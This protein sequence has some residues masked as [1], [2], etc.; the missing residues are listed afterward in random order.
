MNGNRAKRAALRDEIL[1]KARDRVLLMGI[2]N[3]T[4]DSF[5][6]GGRF[7]DPREALRQAEVLDAEGADIIDVGGESTRPSAAQ[8]S[9]ED[10]LG[11]VLAVIPGLCASYSRIVSIDTYKASVAHAAA[12]AGAVIVN[13][14]WGMTRDTGMA[15][16]VAETASAVVVT[17]N[18]GTVQADI[19][20]A[21]DMRDFFANAFAMAAAA[22]IPREHVILDPGVG[23]GKT[24]EQ[25]FTV[26]AR[27]D[28]LMDFDV[29]VLVGVS[30]KSFIGRLLDRE[31]DDRLIGTLAAGLA[32]VQRGA[33][34]LRVH[35]VGA[36]AD[37]LKMLKAIDEAG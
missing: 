4:P 7:V 12:E 35:D 23:F 21:D 14:V 18:R 28:V 32:S 8:V 26:L 19:N 27:L 1:A 15:Q 20:I 2:L 29:P 6:D 10:E 16:A 3:V 24:Y 13:D 33:R 30:R 31:V 11:R 9:A 25:N 17:Y 22:G 37:A 36:H 34:I 5:S